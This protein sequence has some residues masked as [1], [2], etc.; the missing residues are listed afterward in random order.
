MFN[1]LL[2]GFL[3]SLAILTWK[4]DAINDDLFAIRKS[5][6]VTPT[7]ATMS[8]NELLTNSSRFLTPA[9]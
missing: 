6:N 8:F 3:V 4:L 5:R 2:S 9:R 7:F 1:V